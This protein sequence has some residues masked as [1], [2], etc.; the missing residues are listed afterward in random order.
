MQV[1]VLPLLVQETQFFGQQAVAPSAAKPSVQGLHSSPEA[2][3]LPRAQAKQP[4]L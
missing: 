1:V 3:D 2:E 4:V